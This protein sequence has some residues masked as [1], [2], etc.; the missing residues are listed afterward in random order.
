MTKDEALKMAIEL[1]ESGGGW[2]N[3]NK[4][5]INAC[6]EALAGDDKGEELNRKANEV[7]ARATGKE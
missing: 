1:L 5:V 7:W 4:E 3:A 6:K 2:G